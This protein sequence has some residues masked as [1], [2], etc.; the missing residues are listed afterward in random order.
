MAFS[1]EI[2]NMNQCRTI[3]L[4]EVSLLDGKDKSFLAGV[5]WSESRSAMKPLFIFNH[6]SSSAISPIVFG[7]GLYSDNL[8]CCD[9]LT[10]KAL[11]AGLKLGV[12]K[13]SPWSVVWV[14]LLSSFKFC[15]TNSWA[16]QYVIAYYP[17][18]GERILRLVKKG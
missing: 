4:T 11:G 1:H 10:T 13:T 2:L 14:S 6:V 3:K 18:K 16:N 7:R 15:L 12:L 9:R 8:E 5:M 17:K